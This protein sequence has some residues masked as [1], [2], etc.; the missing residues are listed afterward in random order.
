MAARQTFTLR[1][2]GPK[3]SVWTWSHKRKESWGDGAVNYLAIC[4]PL[5]ISQTAPPRLFKR[6]VNRKNNNPLNALSEGQSHFYKSGDEILLSL[7]CQYNDLLQSRGPL[8]LRHCN[9]SLS[10]A[11]ERATL[12]VRLN[13]IM[14]TAN[15]T[16]SP[17][18]LP[19]PVEEAGE[20]WSVTFALPLSTSCIFFVLVHR[21]L[22]HCKNRRFYFETLNSV[23]IISQSLTSL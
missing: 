8:S 7:P 9:L 21:V 4:V 18:L 6:C 14:L 17:S 22:R 5:P 11:R 10:V 15:S 13:A 2:P 19:R 3:Y 16:Q 20:S 12:P 1:A 23:P